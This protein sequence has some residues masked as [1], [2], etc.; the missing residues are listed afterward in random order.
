MPAAGFLEDAGRGQ[1]AVGIFAA[2]P[3][4]RRAGFERGGE[5]VAVRG[6]V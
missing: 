3:Q 4:Q 1:L 5:I 6:A 2:H